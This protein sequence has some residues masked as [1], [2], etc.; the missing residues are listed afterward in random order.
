MA[1]GT[2]S[3]EESMV[4]GGA[5]ALASVGKLEREATQLWVG[6]ANLTATAANT[7]TPTRLLCYASSISR[8]LQHLASA[9]TTRATTSAVRP[10]RFPLLLLLSDVPA[11]LAPDA[12]VPALRIPLVPL[13]PLVPLRVPPLTALVHVVKQ[14]SPLLAAPSLAPI[15]ATRVTPTCSVPAVAVAAPAH[16]VHVSTGSQDVAVHVFSVAVAV[17]AAVAVSVAAVASTA[18]SAASVAST[19]TLPPAHSLTAGIENVGTSP[20][21]C[22]YVTVCPSSTYTPGRSPSSPTQSWYTPSHPIPF[23]VKK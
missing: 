20:P 7:E 1:R 8:Y 9:A 21:P 2:A 15:A 16:G 22:V 18:V 6:L 12:T 10:L 23:D 17:S 4:A 5:G 3:S 19:D 13:V 11:V 14:H